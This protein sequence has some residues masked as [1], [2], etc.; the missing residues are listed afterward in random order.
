MSSSFTLLGR[1]LW[2]LGSVLLAFSV[3]DRFLGRVDPSGQ[4]ATL[5]FSQTGLNSGFAATWIQ[6]SD[7]T[8]AQLS[9]Q[10]SCA[11]VKWPHVK[12][13]LL[14]SKWIEIIWY[15]WKNNFISRHRSKSG[16]FRN[17][18]TEKSRLEASH[19]H[20]EETEQRK[21]EKSAS[22]PALTWTSI[23]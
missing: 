7:T 12:E 21:R 5:K 11:V 18:V 2:L 3:F 8:K 10:N 15:F 9:V 6:I 4:R 22:E 20:K 1:F 19:V 17:S 14:K 23:I 16:P 13:T